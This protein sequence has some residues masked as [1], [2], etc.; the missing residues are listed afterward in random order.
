MST[1]EPDVAPE[2]PGARESPRAEP[3]SGPVKAWPWFGR[4]RR[5]AVIG[6]LLAGL[7]AF[8]IGEAIYEMIPAEKVQQDLMGTKIWTANRA[9]S[10]EAARRNGALTFGVLGLC[11][12]TCLGM[13]GGLARRSPSGAVTGALLGAVLGLALGAGVSWASISWFI[14]TRMDHIDYDLIISLMM[15]GLIWSL[16]GASAGLAFAVG[17]GE[18]WLCGR[19]LTAGFAGAVLGTVA[20]ELI[21]AVAFPMAET[22]EPISETWATRLMAR[23]L[24]TV[25]T[26]LIVILLLPEPKPLADAHQPADPAPQP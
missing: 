11:L 1:N 9:T 17:L 14:M 24:V 22:D 4:T 6:G 3:G 10:T 15:H 2:G 26:A 23:L 21:G 16:L 20:F 7:L 19:C 18:P 13:A 5:L 12:G 8:A 25:G